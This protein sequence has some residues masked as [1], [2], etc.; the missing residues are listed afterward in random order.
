MQTG[1]PSHQPL[2]PN[3][4]RLG[5]LIWHCVGRMKEGSFRQG[6]T[7]SLLRSL[8]SPPPIHP[9]LHRGSYLS[10]FA[11]KRQRR[12][13]YPLFLLLHTIH[14]PSSRQFIDKSHFPGVPCSL[15]VLLALI[16]SQ[17]VDMAACLLIE[18]NITLL[19]SSDP[20][21]M[22]YPICSSSLI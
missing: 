22:L 21:I 10:L 12:G 9:C 13:V 1:S 7:A 8:L 18:K 5:G 15:T 16:L 19:L 4:G 2:M 14:H 20:F 6:S 17:F 3:D 11:Y